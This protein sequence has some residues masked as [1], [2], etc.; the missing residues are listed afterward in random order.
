MPQDAE[1][2]AA[3]NELSF[4]DQTFLPP[5]GTRFRMPI[6]VPHFRAGPARRGVPSDLVAMLVGHIDHV[7]HKNSLLK[8]WLSFYEQPLRLLRTNI[9]AG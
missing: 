5:P 2:S 9:V 3:Q 6:T 8:K 4:T 1:W 7:G